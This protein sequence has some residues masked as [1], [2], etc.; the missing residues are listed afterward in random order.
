M[1]PKESGCLEL[2][3]WEEGTGSGVVAWMGNREWATLAVVHRET[4][5]WAGGERVTFG[6]THRD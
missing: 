5:S 1:Y 6:C 4:A 2:G 3:R